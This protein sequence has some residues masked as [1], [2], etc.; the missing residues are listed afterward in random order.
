MLGDVILPPDVA[1]V[2]IPLTDG[3]DKP[4]TVADQVRWMEDAGLEVTVLVAGGRPGPL[5]RRPPA[6]R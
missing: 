2:V 1:S 3:W 5:P 4:S 6:W